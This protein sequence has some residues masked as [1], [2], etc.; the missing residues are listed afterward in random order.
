MF[1]FVVPSVII[2]V[3]IWH[4]WP[5]SVSLLSLV[6]LVQRKL[7]YLMATVV[8]P[9]T[10]IGANVL[11]RFVTAIDNSITETDIVVNYHYTLERDFSLT[12]DDTFHDHSLLFE[13]HRVGDSSMT[14]L[15]SPTYSVLPPT[16]PPPPP[17]PPS[18]LHCCSCPNSVCMYENSNFRHSAGTHGGGFSHLLTLFWLDLAQ[19]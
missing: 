15:T 6:K 3:G 1:L 8:W 4:I 9:E 14:A 17:K 5:C 12:V 7:V 2:C 10:V 11:D 18:P 13:I 19:S 16:P